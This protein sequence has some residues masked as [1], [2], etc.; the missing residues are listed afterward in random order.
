MAFTREATRTAAAVEVVSCTFVSPNPSSGASM[1]ASFTVIIKFSD[2]SSETRN[3]DL[4]P[5]LTPAQTTTVTAFVASLRT[6]AIAE[7]LPPP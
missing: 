5:H 1:S 6:K 4:L 2:G 3:G 7:F